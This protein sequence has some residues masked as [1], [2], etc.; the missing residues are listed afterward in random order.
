MA[1]FVFW[2]EGRKDGRVQPPR[3][4]QEW[5]ETGFSGLSFRHSSHSRLHPVENV[6]L[7]A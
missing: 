3:N 4:H 6:A 5:P 7:S 1:A 2:C